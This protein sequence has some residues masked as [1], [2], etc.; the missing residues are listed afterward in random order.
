MKPARLVAMSFIALIAFGTVLLLLPVSSASNAS[1]GL[2]TALF[3]A[4]S[5]VCL[6]GLVVV[7]TA[8]YWSHF[9]QL[10]IVL[11]IQLGGL[12]IMTL[13]TLVGW[14]IAGRLDIRSK[15]IAEADGRGN[16]L[17]EVRSLLLGV[18]GFTLATESIV[19]L[20]LGL[21]FH[22]GYGYSVS[23]S[24]WWGVFHSISAFNNAGF[25]LAK[26]NL[27]PFVGDI[28]IIFPIA[29]AIII[30]G[31]GFPVLLE[32]RQRAP[33]KSLTLKFTLWGTAILLVAGAIGI[34]LLEWNQALFVLT[35]P[36]KLLAVGFQS[37]T[38]RT[39]GFNSVDFGQFH[40]ST[41]LLSD[42]LMF[43]GGGSGGTAGG[44]KIT[45][46][47]VILTILIAEIR[48]N[49][50]VE[51]WHK[52]IPPRAIR[53]AL[54]VIMIAIIILGS[55]ISALLILV[56][57]YTTDQ[58]IFEATSAFATVGVSTGITGQLSGP[59]QL[60]LIVLMYVGRVGPIT[61]VAALA[62]RENRKLYSFPE[63][64]PIIG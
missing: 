12:G 11:L 45:T 50:H 36:E 51:V 16:D 63:E 61:V 20:I 30:G 32:L 54:A 62:A 17:G 13:A 15:L 49:N 37:V 1:A 42:V 6:T 2:L 19:A 39:A 33:K 59:A 64:R 10:V 22:F 5:A 18:V 34:A 58:I 44:V 29:L 41:L 31:L 55:A 35:T 9:G 4:T 53:Q 3:T 23:E 21:R 27:V 25:G 28:G 60:I 40:P 47:A 52:R 56:P 26:D 14:F 24:M 46:I 48:G 57:E 38:L 8:T 43:I 7:D